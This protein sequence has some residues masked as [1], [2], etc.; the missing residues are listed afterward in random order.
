MSI[1]WRLRL[2]HS[3]HSAVNVEWTGRTFRFDPYTTPDPDDQ[4]VLT[5][6]ECERAEGTLAAIRAGQN[7]RVIAVPALRMWL[8]EAGD[9]LDQTPGWTVD[10]KDKRVL[11]EAMEYQPIPY[12]T[13][14]E[15]ARKT[16]AAL[17]NPLMAAKR[18][19]GRWSTSRVGPASVIRPCSI[20]IT[21]SASM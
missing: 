15:F 3:G 11:V 5:W 19:R 18:L 13:T 17:L 4:I 10:K 6:H 2:T 12:A 7:P 21:R 20:T 8:H 14:A 9:C 16:K 1:P